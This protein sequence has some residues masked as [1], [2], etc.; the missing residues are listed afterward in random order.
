M[1]LWLF[2]LAVVLIPASIILWGVGAAHGIPWIGLMFASAILAFAN[3]TC[4]PLSINYVIDSYRDM[5]GMMLTIVIIVRNTMYF[6]ISY[7]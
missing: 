3:T 5:S 7:G 2:W 1:R 4:V 6:A